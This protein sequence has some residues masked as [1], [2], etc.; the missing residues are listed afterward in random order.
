MI[1]W[2]NAI[3]A[4]VLIVLVAALYH[5]RYSAEAEIRALRQAERAIIAEADYRQTLQAEWSSLNDPR[6]LQAL[7]ER[8]LALAYLQAEQVIDLRPEEI[9]PITVLMQQGEVF[10][11]PQ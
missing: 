7:A 3:M 11:E 8:Y 6:R 10:N 9:R 5:I 1:R 2:V 4:V